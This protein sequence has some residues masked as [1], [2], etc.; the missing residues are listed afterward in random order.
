MISIITLIIISHILR[1]AS[2]CKTINQVGV[3]AI[4]PANN[5]TCFHYNI[6][7]YRFPEQIPALL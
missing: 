1:N 2:L 5:E 7:G 4:F 3:V 6:D